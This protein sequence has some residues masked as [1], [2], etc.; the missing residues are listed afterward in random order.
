M[1]SEA[2]F[3]LAILGPRLQCYRLHSS[4]VR[5]GNNHRGCKL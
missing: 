3:V 2:R 5:S 1:F 4:F